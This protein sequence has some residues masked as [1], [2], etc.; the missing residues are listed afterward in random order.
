MNGGTKWVFL[1]LLVTL[2]GRADEAT[3]PS[4][5]IDLL[6][7]PLEET[8]EEFTYP[9]EP[10]EGRIASPW[11][12]SPGAGL[13]V[14]ET[15]IGFLRTRE[16]F[17]DFHLVCEYR[18]LERTFGPRADRARDAG[19]IFHLSEAHSREA[20][21]RPARFE[22]QISE[23]ATGDLIAVSSVTHPSSLRARVDRNTPPRWSADAKLRVFDETDQPLARI[24]WSRKSI[25]WIDRRGFRGESDLAN[26]VGE[27][28]RIE[29][30]AQGAS[31]ELRINGELVNAASHLSRK[32]GAIGL[33]A[34]LAA[35]EVRRLELHPLGQ[36]TDSWQAESRSTDMGYSVTGE[37][38]LPRRFPLSPEESASLWEIDGDYR[39]ELVAAEPLVADPVDLTWDHRG[40]LLVAE[41]RDYPLPTAE[42]AAFLSRI[43]RLVDDDGDGR[44]D[45][46]EPWAENLDHVQGLLPFRDGIIATS[47][48]EVL[49]LADLD[50]DGR[51]EVREPLFRT[52]PIQRHY[53]PI[54]ERCLFH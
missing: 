41:M 27:W 31:V 10:S 33:R 2:A 35:F 29:I 18:W 23:G 24:G 1:I 45:R 50:G 9:V 53:P 40:N 3:Q 34:N 19:L 28:N 7:A 46:S 51:A 49:Y 22:A 8:F 20:N 16:A 38:L 13:A 14:S 25:P 48:T 36:F 11:Q 26:P 30:I 42:G 21:L 12:H 52:N 5:T 17:H 32:A 44:Y 15:A 39:I 47:R 43:R 6:S 37:S 4:Q 54:H